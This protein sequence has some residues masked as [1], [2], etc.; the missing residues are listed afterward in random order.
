MSILFFRNYT[1]IILLLVLFISCDKKDTTTNEENNRKKNEVAAKV[2]LKTLLKSIEEKDLESL[3]T[4]MPPTGK[5]ELIMPGRAISHSVDEFVTLHQNWF[6]DTTWTMQT[7][8]LNLRIDQNI[9]FAT[10]DA[11]YK[12]PERNGN[13]YS[14]HMIV[15][16]VLEKVNNKWYVIKDHACSLKKST[17]K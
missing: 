14:N 7:N 15:S 1:G 2:T 17:D 12:E 10:T 8:I 4:T 9:A 16:Y 11:V 3:K 13:P 5:I 6:K